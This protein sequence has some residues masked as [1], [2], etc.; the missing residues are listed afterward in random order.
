[1]IGWN[2]LKD[3]D[4]IEK[5]SKV[6]HESHVDPKQAIEA[7]AAFSFSCFFPFFFLFPSYNLSILQTENTEGRKEHERD[8]LTI[9]TR[10][11]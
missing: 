3:R 6:S 7:I 10:G 9:I 1:M 2:I 5:Y 8:A 4:K 11:G